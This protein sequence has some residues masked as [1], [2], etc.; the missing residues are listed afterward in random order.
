MQVAAKAWQLREQARQALCAGNQAAQA[1]ALAQASCQLH[2]TPRGQRLLA[3]AL[4]ENGYTAQAYRLI[5]ELQ[6]R[7]E[8]EA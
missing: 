1:L 6:N 5:E 8:R 7:G 3:V 2:A 4:L